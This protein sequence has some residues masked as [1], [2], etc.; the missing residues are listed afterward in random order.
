M[1]G[2]IL[3]FLSLVAEKPELARKLGE[4]A[5][6]FDFE[7][8]DDELSDVDLEAVAGGTGQTLSNIGEKEQLSSMMEM[9]R[10]QKTL[11][12]L[13]NIMKKINDTQDSL[14]NNIK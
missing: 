3:D 13:S 11:Q 5:A 4:L 6:E 1:K 14:I 10:R 9:D 12:T 8:V 2:T 7:F